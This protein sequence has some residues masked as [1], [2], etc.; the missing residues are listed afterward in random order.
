MKR[1][2]PKIKKTLK[3]FILDE[4]AKVINK[5]SSKV[6][7]T[8]SFLA[9]NFLTNIDNAHA[10]GHGDHSNHENHIFK[11]GNEGVVSGSDPMI[12]EKANLL[13]LDNKSV[14]VNLQVQ[15]YGPSAQEIP[16]KSITS[17]HGNHYNHA[18]GGGSS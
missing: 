5:T 11:E 9:F 15:G 6:A 2:L 17:A 3:S 18:D 10:Q 4:D 14:A 12:H 8:I 13:N 1:E 16:T 7:L